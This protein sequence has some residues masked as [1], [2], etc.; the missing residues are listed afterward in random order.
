M[1]KRG[2]INDMLSQRT[3]LA[4]REVVE[5][6]D[7]YTKQQVDKSDNLQ[8]DMTTSREVDKNTSIPSSEPTSGQTN[9]KSKPLV[10]KYTTHLRPETI[11]AVKRVALESDRKDYEVV[12]AAL[13]QYLQQ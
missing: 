7:M 1:S 6:V 2:N 5:P 3:P 13:D 8:V 9:K 4:Q 10:E 11:K 12:Q